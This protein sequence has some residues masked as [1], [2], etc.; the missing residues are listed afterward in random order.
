M[1][2]EAL[3]AHVARDILCVPGSIELQQ[4]QSSSINSSPGKLTLNKNL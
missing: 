3:E 2:M 1:S 4:G